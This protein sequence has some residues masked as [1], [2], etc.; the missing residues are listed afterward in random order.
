MFPGYDQSSGRYASFDH[1]KFSLGDL[2][3][4]G[5]EE[6][7]ARL[8]HPLREFH[9]ANDYDRS[10]A[11]SALLTAAIRPSLPVA[12]AFNYTASRPGSGKTLLSGV[13]SLFAGPGEPQSVSYPKTSEEATKEVLSL[14]IQSPAVV[15][16]DDMDRDWLPHGS[17]N[18][19]LTSPVVTDRILGSS[20]TATV[21]TRTLVLGSGNN[22]EP[23]KDLRRRVISIRLS[24]P[25]ATPALLKYSGD[26]VGEVSRNR[27]RLVSDALT[28]I[29][30]WRAAGCPRADVSPIASYNGAWSDFCRYPLLWLGLPDP[31]TSLLEQVQT[32]PDNEELGDLLQASMKKFG[33][34]S[35]TVR[36]IID[37]LA[38][39]AS[40]DLY[41][42]VLALPVT[43]GG[44]I[45]PGSLG[46]YLKK[47]RGRIVDG[48]M[49]DD[50]DLKERKSWRV[51]RVQDAL[52]EG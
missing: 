9:F 15:I 6:A 42:A 3:R 37:A 47:Q 41:Q 40:Q 12:P 14:L 2:T 33:D 13:T 22:V 19:M 30:A 18:R 8:Q 49:I 32:D 1:E 20:K 48:L 27:E 26:P 44:T 39:T 29:Q 5:A 31:A 50:G 24:P 25:T 36:Q 10:A 11:I 35:F 34:R 28:I 38:Q 51:L 7:L 43:Q 52:H 21:S 16:F 45:N 23:L 4:R 46:W 17:I